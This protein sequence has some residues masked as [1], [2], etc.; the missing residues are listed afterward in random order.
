MGE[1]YAHDVSTGD[2]PLERPRGHAFISYVHEDSERVDRLVSA[3][4]DAGV[5]VWRDKNDIAPGQDWRREIQRAIT[6]G[7]LV[8]VACFSS[9]YE[10]KNKSYQNEELMLA[11]EQI[12]LRPAGST[13]YIPVRFDECKTPQHDIGAGRNLSSIQHVDLF[14][15]N[16][17]RAFR[18]LL[19][20]IVNVLSANRTP[21]M[22]EPLAP[23]EISSV[24]PVERVRKMILDS[25]LRLQV[26]DIYDDAVE[27]L[28]EI[29][30][31]PS[32]FP[33]RFVPDSTQNSQ[34]RFVVDQAHAYCKAARPLAELMAV[35]CSSG[36][37]DYHPVWARVIQNLAGSLLKFEGGASELNSIRTLPLIMLAYTACTAAMTRGD[38]GVIR[39]VAVDA[40]YTNNHNER[41]PI[42]GTLHTYLPFDGRQ[43]R[44]AS[45]LANE[46]DGTKLTDDEFERHFAGRAAKRFTPVSDYIHD[47][48]RPIFR[49]MLP[50]DS[51]YSDVF[52][53][54]EIY[55]GIVAT[56]EA[57]RVK[58]AGAYIHGPWFGSFTWRNRHSVGERIEDRVL[59][60]IER[61]DWKGYQARLLGGSPE[62][63]KS[64]AA[65]FV[66]NA[67]KVRS[68]RF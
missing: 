60:E 32:R 15:E 53:L 47:M 24:S 29:Y 51:D 1:R 66:A 10:R 64:A 30:S 49:R 18:R 22:Y 58:D 37:V 54:T 16:W 46:S 62:T 4:E 6:E 3:L 36:A 68:Q 23:R 7:A 65:E 14:D 31:S 11:I 57:A 45:A 33:N 8:F 59:G 20:A 67:K 28:R 52:D 63:A 13:W 48:I 12:R 55:L 38:F 41:V 19:A 50:E 35:G 34:A 27:D 39:A 43:E 9:N 61:P 40:K 56:Y 44:M 26:E 25:T 2:A 5:K 17:E 42:V 21:A